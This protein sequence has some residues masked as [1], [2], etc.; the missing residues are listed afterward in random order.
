[1]STLVPSVLPTDPARGGGEHTQ[2]YHTPDGNGR[3][4]APEGV[5]VAAGLVA[6][7]TTSGKD[8]EGVAHIRRAQ[9][10]PGELSA[11]IAE[12]V[13]D[14]LRAVAPLAA[15]RT[16][17]QRDASSMHPGDDDNN[18]NHDNDD[19]N[20]G[21]ASEETTNYF[22]RAVMAMAVLTAAVSMELN[23]WVW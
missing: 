17:L 22:S 19:S 7:S 4:S 21:E 8:E 5:D 18:D 12:G 23:S 20:E 13:R 16:P 9:A 14:T 6:C 3:A 10:Y 1:M 11:A 15:N 2:L